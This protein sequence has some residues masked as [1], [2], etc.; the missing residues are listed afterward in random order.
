MKDRK[1]NVIAPNNTARFSINTS[2]VRSQQGS[3]ASEKNQDGGG[4]SAALARCR[5]AQ[6]SNNDESCTP[7][8]PPIAAPAPAPTQTFSKPTSAHAS[9]PPSNAPTRMLTRNRLPPSAPTTVPST[10]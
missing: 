7:R 3:S 9:P 4:P 2:T 8:N 6:R 1:T 5:S 10:I